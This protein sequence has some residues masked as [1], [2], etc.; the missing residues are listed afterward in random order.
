MLSGL[1]ATGSGQRDDFRIGM[2]PAT[3]KASIV[4]NPVFSSV[5]DV[6]SVRLLEFQHCKV[7]SHPSDLG[8]QQV[9]EVLY[10]CRSVYHLEPKCLTGSGHVLLRVS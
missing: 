10:A 6:R 9:A 7:K 4:D 8:E 5:V 1:I 3:G 2:R